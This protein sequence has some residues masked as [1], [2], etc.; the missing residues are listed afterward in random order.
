MTKSIERWNNQQSGTSRSLR[1]L[2][3]GLTL[4][5]AQIEQVKTN[6]GVLCWTEGKEKECVK[7]LKF[8]LRKF[9]PKWWIYFQGPGTSP[10]SGL[11][12]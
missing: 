9:R 6:F 2:A 12:L 5:Q 1:I 3:R 8:W 4:Q 10:A 11:L 7:K